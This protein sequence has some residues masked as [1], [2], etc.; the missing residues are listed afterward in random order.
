MKRST[1]KSDCF[2]LSCA[3]SEQYPMSLL[4]DCFRKLM[5]VVMACSPLRPL[6]LKEPAPSKRW[7]WNPGSVAKAALETL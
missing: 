1:E 4:P 6:V 2:K 3:L 5:R 7:F